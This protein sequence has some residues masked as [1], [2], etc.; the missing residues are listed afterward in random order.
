MSEAR[1][2]DE[3]DQEPI[4]LKNVSLAIPKNESEFIEV[5]TRMGNEGLFAKPWNLQSEATLREFLFK[6][7]NQ[8][9]RTIRHDLEKWTA[10]V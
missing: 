10:E 6:K 5:L 9:F 4:P 3:I 2:E 7:G 1:E 8:W